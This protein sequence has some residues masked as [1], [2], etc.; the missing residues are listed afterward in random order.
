MR[1]F[2]LGDEE[3][4]LGFSLTGLSG[5]VAQ[6]PDDVDAG[7]DQVL[8]TPDIGILLITADAAN[9]ARERVDRLKIAAALP[10]ILEIPSSQGVTAETSIRR[11]I[12]EAIGVSL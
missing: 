12:S 5:R 11:F 4:V 6:T 10:L 8:D 7:L 9:M 1:L 2:V 3:A